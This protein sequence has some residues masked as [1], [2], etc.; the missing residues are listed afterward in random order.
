MTYAAILYDFLWK[1]I[2]LALII[3]LILATFISLNLFLSLKGS[4][5]LDAA[6]DDLRCSQGELASIQDLQFA[7]RRAASRLVEMSGDDYLTN[8]RR[9]QAEKAIV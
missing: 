3:L 9:K 4:V 8:W 5:P 6:S 7:C 1:R 2:F